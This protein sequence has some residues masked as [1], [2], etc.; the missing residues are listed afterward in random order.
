MNSALEGIP[1]LLRSRASHKQSVF[2]ASKRQFR[3]FK[4]TSAALARWMQAHQ[5]GG[6]DRV[7]IAHKELNAYAFTL[8]FGG[9]LLYAQQH[10]NV[11]TLD[12][13]SRLWNKAYVQEDR[14]RAYFGVFYFY[15]FL[16][17]SFTYQRS[18]DAGVLLARVFINAE[19]FFFIEGLPQ[20]KR[21]LQ[22]FQ[23]QHF[24]REERKRLMGLLV[25]AAIAYDLTAPPLKEVWL[26]SVGDIQAQRS[27]SLMRTGKK[28]GYKTQRDLGEE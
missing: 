12:Q 4:D 21:P 5:A 17:D 26:A 25:Q 22:D 15:N 20:F 6:D 9:D 28:L 1:G 18:S 10:T 14:S 23:Y 7:V 24:N 8:Q 11:F 13:K 19:G 3:L 27:E 2:A 16:A